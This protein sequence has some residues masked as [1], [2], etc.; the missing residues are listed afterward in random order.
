MH[1]CFSL[2]LEKTGI[3]VGD[4]WRVWSEEGECAGVKRRR[5][6]VPVQTRWRTG[7]EQQRSRIESVGCEVPSP[8]PP[9]C[10][11]NHR[12]RKGGKYAKL[13]THG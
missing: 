12:E 6:D 8:L 13:G 9:M 5:V 1:R 7:R 4:D 10:S 2:G 3:E 11:S